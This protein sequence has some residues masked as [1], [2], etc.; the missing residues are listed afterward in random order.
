MDG[1]PDPRHHV[2][3]FN[4]G[5][6]DRRSACRTLACQCKSWDV[7]DKFDLD[8]LRELFVENLKKIEPFLGA[9]GNRGGGTPPTVRIRVGLSHWARLAL[10]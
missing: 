3:A 8:Y 4:S 1:D 5:S 10:E 6:L 9:S 7:Q 2:D